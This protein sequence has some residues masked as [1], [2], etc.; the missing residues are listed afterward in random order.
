MK[1]LLAEWSRAGR[2]VR[3]ANDR[4][5]AREKLVKPYCISDDPHV[6]A[7]AIEA[8]A[9]VVVTADKNLIVDLRNKTLMGKKLRIYKESSGNPRRVDRHRSLL[10]ASDCA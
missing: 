8:R 9:D 2:L 6:V 10:N 3:I 5:E 1:G 4:I 7:L